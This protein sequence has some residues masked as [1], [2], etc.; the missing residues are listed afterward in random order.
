LLSKSLSNLLEKEIEKLF[1]TIE[2]A[3]FFDIRFKELKFYFEKNQ[4]YL[5]GKVLNLVKSL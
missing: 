1:S 5:I 3:A 4:K 2:I